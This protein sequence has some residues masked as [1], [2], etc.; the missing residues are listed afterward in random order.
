MGYMAMALLPLQI[1]T[2]EVLVLGLGILLFMFTD[3]R[4][5]G[6]YLWNRN[7]AGKLV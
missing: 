5:K 2:Y 6:C 3:L 4:D 1:L 7:S